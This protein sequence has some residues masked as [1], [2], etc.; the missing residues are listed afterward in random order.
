MS[1]ETIWTPCV[2]RALYERVVARFGA[3]STWEQKSKPGKGMNEAFDK[4]CEDFAKL[5]G[6]RSGSAV[7]HSI[8]FTQPISKNGADWSNH[9]RQAIL[10]LAAAHEAGFID[11]S[12]FP[13]RMRVGGTDK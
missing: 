13:T 5:F 1:K 10:N 11:Y 3:Y 12:G 4:F 2:R 8:R 7:H 9:S 6:M